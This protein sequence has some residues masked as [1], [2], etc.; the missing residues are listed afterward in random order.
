MTTTIEHHLK[1]IVERPPVTRRLAAIVIADV[2][3]YARLMERNEAGTHAELREIREQIVDPKIAE[4]GGRIVKT[5]GDGMVVEFPSASAALACAVDV[6]RAMG[7]RNLYVADDAKIQFR[8]GINLGDILIDGDDIAGDGVNVAARLEALAEPGGICIGSAVHEQVH[9][10]LGFGFVDIG[11]QQVKNI[12]RPIRAYRVT[13]GRGSAST[14]RLKTA[15]GGKRWRWMAGALGLLVVAFA[16]TIFHRDGHDNGAPTPAAAPGGPPAMSIAILPFSVMGGAAADEALS[17]SLSREVTAAL[18]RT[19]RFAR[20]VS[21]ALASGYKGRATDARAVGRDLN[22][23]YLAQGEIHHAGDKVVIDT[24]LIDTANATQVWTDRMD[25]G[26]AQGPVSDA[27]PAQLARRIRNAL[28]DAETRRLKHQA[29]TSASAVELW[30]RGVAAIGDGTL[31]ETRDGEKYFDEALRV[32]P[33]LVG[34]LYGKVWTLLNIVTLDPK[35]DRDRLLQKADEFSLRAVAADRN[36]LRAWMTRFDALTRQWRWSEAVQALAEVNRIDP[37]YTY[38]YHDQAL[39]LI[40][41]GRPEEVAAQLD[42]A[43]ALDPRE[44]DD[45]D[46]LFIR[47]RAALSMGRYESAIDACERSAASSNDWTTYMFLTAA[48]AQKGDTA[49]AAATKARLLKVWPDFTIAQVK[50]AAISDNPVFWQQTE[51]HV[52]R[53]LRKAGIPEQ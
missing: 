12:V 1:P 7:H 44:A 21:H 15:F 24:T 14:L 28:T 51:T 43:I 37:T 52:F 25:V 40:W 31:Q 6:Q 35:A 11:E 5:A 20:I 3:G 45:S 33:A 36:D 18:G 32:D 47:C 23:R 22:V 27:V 2:A 46:L 17:E 53:G 16:A 4:Y 49:K 8:I 9:D 41:T 29:G 39:L 19:A 30:L 50:N 26:G 38:A 48:Y 42:K 10:D 34:A 13:L